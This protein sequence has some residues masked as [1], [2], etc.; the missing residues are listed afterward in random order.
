MGNAKFISAAREFFAVAATEIELLLK[1]LISNYFACISPHNCKI[2]EWILITKAVTII[3]L[4]SF[5]LI[6]I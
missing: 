1:N 5:N 4:F 6:F 3:F 2:Y